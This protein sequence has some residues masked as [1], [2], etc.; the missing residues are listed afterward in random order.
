MR[1]TFH[2]V[3]AESWAAVDRGAAYRAP[4]LVTEGFIHCTDGADAVIETANRYYQSD[5]RPYVVLTIDLD[6]TGSPW[7][8]DDPEGIYPHV[9][10]PIDQAA[11]V[12]VAEVRRTP[13]GTFV[14]I[15]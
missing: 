14:E 15:A 10:G 1:P 6:A 5:D 12:E 9:Y 3:P 8:A 13:D 4:T 2:L 7:R 11:I